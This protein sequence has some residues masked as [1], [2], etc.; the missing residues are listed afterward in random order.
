MVALP[1]DPL[2]GAA[3]WSDYV[4]NWRE[5][6]AEWIQARTILRFQTSAARDAAL[7][8]AGAGQFIYNGTNDYLEYRSSSG[9]WKSYKATPNYLAGGQQDDVSGVVFAHANAAG[10]GIMLTPT[11]V[12]T[13]A[14]LN[15][16]TNTMLVDTTGINLK[17]GAKTVK[18]ST[19]AANLVSDSPIS[20]PSLSLSGTGTVIVAAGKTMSIG[21]ITADVGTI[22]NINMSGTLTGGVLNGSRATINSTISIGYD[23]G[24]T[25]PA[26]STNVIAPN[27][28]VSQQGVF[29][30]DATSAYMR[31]R[32]PT[33]A[34]LSAQYIQVTA[35]D[36]NFGPTTAPNSVFMYPYLRIMQGHGVPWHNSGGTHVAWISP[37]IYSGS[38]P[39]AG[40]YPDGTLWLS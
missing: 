2:Y 10:K 29:Y 39:G 27:G 40:N 33:T 15:V 22:T 32:V 13:S 37:V 23:T 16:L 38:D 20:A 28:F 35:T 26:A 36:I 11:Q 8:G 14:P 7:P 19:D 5:A 4:D 12:Q 34:A 1:V 21:T 30:G 25:T 3:N 9:T 17:V 18:L 24:L 6:D 31:Q